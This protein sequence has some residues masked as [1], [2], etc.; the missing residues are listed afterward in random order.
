MN[1]LNKK[2]FLIQTEAEAIVK[3]GNNPHFKS[4]YATLNNVLESIVPLL[5]KHKIVLRQSV[6]DKHLE[7]YLSDTENDETLLAVKYPLM[8]LN[9]NNPQH[10]ASCIT[11]ARRYS[12]ISLFN[13]RV[14][15]DDANQASG[16]AP[17]KPTAFSKIVTIKND[18]N[19]QKNKDD[20]INL[21]FAFSA[22]QFSQKFDNEAK[23]KE[24]MSKVQSYFKTKEEYLAVVKT[25]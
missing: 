25:I 7:T 23:Y 13:L 3:D 18:A 22:L 15:D 1:N 17:T 11:Y 6:V 16:L 12:L 4:S 24:V 20:Y 10:F 14:E 9:D 2:L 8:A 21:G 19:T 5:N